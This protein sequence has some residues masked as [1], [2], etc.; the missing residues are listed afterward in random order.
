MKTS[1]TQKSTSCNSYSSKPFFN[2]SGE[3]SFFSQTK[4]VETP[5]FSPYSIQ[6]KLTVGQP[7]DEYEQE[8]DMTAEKVVRKLE[9][10]DH[11]YLIQ[12]SCEDCDKDEKIQ[13]KR[14]MTNE[15]SIVNPLIADKVDENIPGEGSKSFEDF[16]RQFF[17]IE[18]S[19]LSDITT[20]AC[21]GVGVLDITPFDNKVIER[22][23]CV[24]NL[25]TLVQEIYRRGTIGNS[26]QKGFSWSNISTEDQDQL[27]LLSILVASDCSSENL[28][29]KI[30]QF[31]FEIFGLS[32]GTAA[33][34][35]G[36]TVVGGVGGVAL[37]A[38]AGE[39]GEMM[40]DIAAFAGQNLITHD[41]KT[42]LPM[43]QKEACDRLIDK[44]K[45]RAKKMYKD[46]FKPFFGFGG[47][48]TNESD[49]PWIISGKDDSSQQPFFFNLNP[50]QKSD[51][52]H[53]IKEKIN[54]D[55]DAIWPNGKT[56]EAPNEKVTIYNAKGAFK[57]E[58]FD[59]ANILGEKVEGY[60]I[61]DYYK[62]LDKPKDE[63]GY[64]LSD[65]KKLNS[66]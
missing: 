18:K 31:I 2:K 4:E 40:L 58:D 28:G 15:D 37:G 55:V 35:G 50:D 12:R 48:V 42:M 62:Y 9:Y 26:N 66:C 65:K 27:M 33:E 32:A 13:K 14:V 34:P 46:H 56:V 22:I 19:I 47:E 1:K 21:L 10:T 64:D 49:V 25:L 54:G 16:F 17:L 38:A 63:L 30:V 60:K 29:R 59:N 5:F 53:E 36:G 43:N 61:N 51:D 45:I 11:P 52:N 57:I 44:G 41:G 6:T 24:C 7:N 8:A 39:L 3:A 20:C 23:D